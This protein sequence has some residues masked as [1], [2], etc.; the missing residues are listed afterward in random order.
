VFLPTFIEIQL[1]N[2]GHTFTLS[3]F[4]AHRSS[5]FMCII[6]SRGMHLFI[7]L[8]FVLLTFCP[9]SASTTTTTEKLLKKKT[10]CFKI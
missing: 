5:R 6:Q 7:G 2:M 9:T 8:Y 1:D 10:R 3:S 4:D